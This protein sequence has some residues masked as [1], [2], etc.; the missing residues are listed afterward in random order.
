[1]VAATDSA[2]PVLPVPPLL[3]TVVPP[4]DGNRYQRIERLPDELDEVV[5]D[6]VLVRG[7]GVG[8]T[9][10]SS[11]SVIAVSGFSRRIGSPEAG[12]SSVSLVPWA[13]FTRLERP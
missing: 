1:V 9:P 3:I 12:I 4:P 13:S 11:G 8:D 6:A 7:V 2:E 5:L 10:S